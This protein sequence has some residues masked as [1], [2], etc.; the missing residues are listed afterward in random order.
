[1]SKQGRRT[2]ASRNRNSKR[3]SQRNKKP[4]TLRLVGYVRVSTEDQAVNGVSIDAQ[5]ERLEAYAT[6]HGYQLIGI[7]SD[8]GASGKI[9]PM[10]RAGL[11]RALETIGNGGADGIVFLKLDR[12][13]RSVRDV[14][15]LADAAK[16]QGWHLVSVQ[17]NIDSSTATGKMILTVLAALAEMERDQVSER[18]KAALDQVAR[19]GR[20]RSSRLPFGYRINGAPKATTVKAGDTRQLVEH[21]EEIKILTRMMKLYDNDKGART[22]A[23]TL[24]AQGMINPRKR[25]PWNPS[26][27]ASIIRTVKRRDR[28]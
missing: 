18:T 13:S 19:E 28:I 14:L 20:A 11:R 26:T 12:L 15:D 3:Q 16:R 27:V 23:K 4:D 6:A 7:E 1:M 5:R 8:N 25:A 24:N 2:R 17:E 21:P 9:P 22:I 10:K